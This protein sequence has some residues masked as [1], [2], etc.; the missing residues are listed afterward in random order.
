MVA[1]LAAFDVDPA[2]VSI[3]GISAGAFM[4]HQLHVAYSDVFCGAGLIAGGAYRVSQ[5]T[6]IGAL[7]CGMKGHTAIPADVLA[8]AAQTLAV[9]GRIAPLDNLK[10]DKVWVFHGACD[11]KVTA[12]SSETLISFYRHFVPESALAYVDNVPVVHAMPT[13][14]FGSP[15]LAKPRL[16]YIANCGYDA[17]GE[18]LTHL[19][20]PLKSREF[21]LK[22]EFRLFDQRPFL[23]FGVNQ[24]MDTEGFLY[25]PSGALAGRRCGVHVVLH[26]CRQH[27]HAVGDVFVRN[28]G[29]NEWAEANDIILV[30]PQARAQMDMRVYNPVAAWDFWGVEDSDYALRSGR[31]M[32]AVANMARAVSGQPLFT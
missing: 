30:Y 20:G 19:H 1:S 27:R 13:D 26:G 10:N 22:G 25:V 9:R 4:A 24:S 23:D 28:A 3:S 11:D 14:S 29:F 21:E 5:G 8:H 18:M 15:A 2:R 12:H 17:A 6:L 31:Q 16:P 32:K 7:V